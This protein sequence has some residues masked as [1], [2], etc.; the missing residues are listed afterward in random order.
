ML[1]KL[2]YISIYLTRQIPILDTTSWGFDFDRGIDQSN[3]YVT[4]LIAKEHPV[5]MLRVAVI[6]DIAVNRSVV[7]HC[8]MQLFP[9]ENAM[10]PVMFP[11]HIEVP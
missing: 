11:G 7:H 2:F 1:I 10:V 6:S 4:R 3:G 5:A 8:S 9:H